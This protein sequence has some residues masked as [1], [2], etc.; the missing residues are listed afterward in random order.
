MLTVLG[1]VEFNSARHPYPRTGI[2]AE[3]CADLADK[4]RALQVHYRREINSLIALPSASP[5][6]CASP[7]TVNQGVI[8]AAAV[9]RIVPLAQ[10]DAEVLPHLVQTCACDK[11]PCA[12]WRL[13]VCFNRAGVAYRESLPVFLKALRIN[14]II[15]L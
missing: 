13:A 6:I 2:L 10:F 14:P 1:A 4:P 12:V 3:A 15:S 9:L 8:S 5:P 7:E 11:A